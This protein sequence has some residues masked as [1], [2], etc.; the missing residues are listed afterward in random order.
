M[1][2]SHSIPEVQSKL[3]SLISKGSG[4]IS[5]QDASAITGHSLEQVEDS[6]ARLIELYKSKVSVGE[7]GKLIFDF[8][9][10]L[11]Q[12]NKKTSKEIF[13]EYGEK[14]WKVFQ[15]VY[16]AA[17]GV[18]LVIYTIVF[19]LIM[20]A[21]LSSGNQ[22]GNRNNNGSKIISGIF[23]AIF[24][25]LRI[26]FYSRAF[27]YV[28]DGQGHRYKR[29]VE[30]QNKGESF[31][32][33]VFNYV[34][35]PERPKFDPLNDAKEMAAY[36]RDKKSHI[37]SA[38]IINLSGVSFDE[39]DSRLAEYAVK[40]RGHLHINENDVAIAEFDDME[41]RVSELD[42]GKIEYY[43]DE[44]EPP[45]ELTGNKSGRD[46]AISGMNFF[47]LIVSMTFAFADNT[48]QYLAS[49][50]IFLG[51]IPF[52][53]S[54]SFFVIPMIRAFVLGAKKHKRELDI[55]RKN[56]VGVIFSNKGKPITKREL[57]V[58]SG[59]KINDR[60]SEIVLNKL[61]P[62]LQGDIVINEAGEAIFQFIRI[63][64][65]LSVFES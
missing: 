5:P 65:E 39:A 52:F 1:N 13:Y 44:I 7:D 22:K 46:I 21:L 34:F 19:A 10:P 48:E 54:L 25:G 59:L 60:N 4:R 45:Y 14:L 51:W 26:S 43:V 29:Y 28:S 35:G 20:L 47:N 63:E 49:I 12:R 31:V 61:I 23:N 8:V 11:S 9:T 33:S 30:S 27:N 15:V 55:I 38:D 58:R 41:K 53:F 6:L 50:Q 57:L 64:K 2:P 42:G 62:E 56:M 16:K 37:T 3:E 17:I 24:M 36:I 18:I 40:F 32:Q